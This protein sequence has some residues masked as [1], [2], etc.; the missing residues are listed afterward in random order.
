MLYNEIKRNLFDIEVDYYAHCISFDCKMGAG[1]AVPIAKKFHIRDGLKRDKFGCP[2]CVKTG[3]VYNL[4]TKK[5]YYGKPTYETLRHSLM[6]M[7]Q[8]IQNKVSIGMP[9]IGCGLDR[10]Q[11]CEVRNII[12]DVFKNRN[13][14]IIVCYI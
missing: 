11:W 5:K 1:I 14:T 7:E 13:I 6:R 10:L 3:K 12:H 9:K 2:D 4:I 8:Q